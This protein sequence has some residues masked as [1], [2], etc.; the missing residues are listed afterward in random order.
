MMTGARV[1]GGRRAWEGK[2]LGSK[3]EHWWMPA[4]L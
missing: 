1:V 2:W 3:A 4:G